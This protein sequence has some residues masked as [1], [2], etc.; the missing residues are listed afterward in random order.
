MA[1]LTKPEALALLAREVPASAPPVLDSNDLDDLV[2]LMRCRDAAG[3]TPADAGYVDSYDRVLLP[4]AAAKA[5]DRKA[6]RVANL[7]TFTADGATHNAGDLHV[8]CL[9][10]A[11]QYRA[12][13]HG[14]GS[15]G[16][17]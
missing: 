1:L 2:L 13:C 12:R 11:R 6:A 14:S 16:V 5:W 10:M 7:E 4:W 8:Q 3:L 9:R 17:S 15:G